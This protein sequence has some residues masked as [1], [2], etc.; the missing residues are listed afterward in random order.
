MQSVG[1]KV[2]CVK[3]LVEDVRKGW[4]LKLFKNF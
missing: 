4:K 2:F 3:E 1:L